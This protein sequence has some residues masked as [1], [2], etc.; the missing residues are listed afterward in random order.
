MTKSRILLFLF[1]VVSAT[2][3][4][5]LPRYV[6]SNNSSEIESQNTSTQDAPV[7]AADTHAREIPDSLKVEL[8]SLYDS[9]K[10][11]E[12]QEKRFIFA[13]SLAEA[14]KTVGKLDSLA[15]YSEVRALEVPSLENLIKAGNGYYEAFN[16][17]VD[18]SKRNNLAEKARRPRRVSDGPPSCRRW[19]GR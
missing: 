5:L 4:Y 1:I 16:F 11:A 9:Y 17:A 14:F 15:K 2:A 8:E 7:P 19:P 12:N 13:D 18:P 6:V 3:L 10:N